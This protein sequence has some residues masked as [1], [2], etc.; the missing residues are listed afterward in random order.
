MAEFKASGL[1]VAEK[2]AKNEKVDEN[3]KLELQ[4]LDQEA[5][6]ALNRLKKESISPE[7][8][9]IEQQITK[10][11]IRFIA[12]METISLSDEQKQRLTESV[13]NYIKEYPACFPMFEE[14]GCGLAGRCE[15]QMGAWN[16]Q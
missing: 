11:P 8:Q 14:I 16:C 2:M 5:D 13:L 9:K 7:E 6:Q 15:K 12:N 4:N 1:P 10:D 3:V